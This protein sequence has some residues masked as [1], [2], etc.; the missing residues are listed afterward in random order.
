M[1]SSIHI[2]I[3][4]NDNDFAYLIKTAIEAQPDMEMVGCCSAKDQAIV[5]AIQSNPDIVLM[6][7]N[8]S[9]A[10]M[11]GIDA[12]KEIHLLT[13]AKV[14]ILTAFE[15]PKIVIEASKKS[16]ASGYIFKSQFEFLVETIRATVHGHTPQEEMI[17][18]LILNDLTAAEQAVLK[19]LLGHDRQLLSSQKTIANQKTV[20]LRKLGLKSQKDLEKTFLAF[21]DYL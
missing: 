15:S 7:L 9:S 12:A 8:L 16:F 5:M 13:K 2:M 10:N 14:I 6:D 4:E 21:Q 18:S 3:V 20:I 19:N 1:S 11:D 17:F